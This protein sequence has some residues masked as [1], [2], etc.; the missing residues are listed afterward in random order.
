MDLTFGEAFSARGLVWTEKSS[1]GEYCDVR[2]EGRRATPL[3]FWITDNIY[4]SLPF[5]K[6]LPI[7]GII[8]DLPQI[9]E[10]H[11]LSQCGRK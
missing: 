11:S 2:K 4:S 3:E 6:A 10:R 5:S 7:I 9:G 8:R 1:V